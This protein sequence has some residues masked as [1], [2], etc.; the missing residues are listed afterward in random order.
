MFKKSKYLLLPLKQ[1]L[2]NRNNDRQIQR[3]ITSHLSTIEDALQV[4]ELQQKEIFEYL[5]SSEER[6]KIPFTNFLN[7]LHRA[8]KKTEKN[9]HSETGSKLDDAQIKL[10]RVALNDTAKQLNS[11]LKESTQKNL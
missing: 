10:V 3:I 8:R 1:D 2:G 6:Q 5:F 7:W 11:A 9:E 4:G